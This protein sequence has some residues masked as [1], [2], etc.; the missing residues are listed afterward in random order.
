MAATSVVLVAAEVLLTHVS[1]AEDEGEQGA[2]GADD[3]VAHGQEVVLAAKC[4]GG[5]EDEVL[6]ALEG[7]HGVVVL[8]DDLVTRA[9]HVCLNLATEF[10]EVRQTGGSHPNNEVFY[11]R[12]KIQ[13]LTIF[14]IEPL[15]L[16]PG[17]AAEF[18]GDIFKVAELV[19]DIR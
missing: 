12:Q 18:L 7:V 1:D 16:I 11:Q 14:H 17:L 19:L 5:R 3:D 15:D 6:L 4:V 2:E 9:F 8:D 13:I 10:S